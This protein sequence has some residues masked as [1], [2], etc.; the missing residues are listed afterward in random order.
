MRRCAREVD[1]ARVRG[2]VSFFA[3]L[4]G[5]AVEGRGR[6]VN[7]D[8]G[9]SDGG[10]PGGTRA[11]RIQQPQANVQS[12]PAGLSSRLSVGGAS[13]HRLRV[14]REVALARFTRTAT[15]WLEARL[16]VSAR[17]N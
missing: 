13:C 6:E 8:G 12:T 7:G 14:A 1:A 5:V 17:R 9:V 10:N 15:R 16:A 4:A 2:S 3:R 11:R